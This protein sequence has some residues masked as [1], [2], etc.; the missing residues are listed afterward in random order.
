MNRHLQLTIPNLCADTRKM[1]DEFGSPKEIGRKFGL[2]RGIACCPSPPYD[3]I[4]RIGEEVGKMVIP[5]AGFSLSTCCSIEQKRKDEKVIKGGNILARKIV[6]VGGGL[7]GSASALAARKAGCEVE[8]FERTDILLGAPD[9]LTRSCGIM[10]AL[11]LRKK[12]SPWAAGTFL[13]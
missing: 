6:V 9:W 5:L 12:P 1:A 4:M 3:D 7:A 13:K 2:T 11:P 8:L 10:D